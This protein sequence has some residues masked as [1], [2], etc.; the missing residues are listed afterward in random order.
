MSNNFAQAKIRRDLL[1][2]SQMEFP[3]FTVN[4]VYKIGY[5]TLRSLNKANEII[6][7]K[8][9]VKKARGLI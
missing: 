1:Q 8:N 3:E 9:R 5:T 7:G 2:K 6:S 4:D